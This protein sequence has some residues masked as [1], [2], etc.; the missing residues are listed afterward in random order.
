M[1]DD[2]ASRELA[3][4]I[5]SAIEREQLL[6]G[7]H[8]LLVACSGG[9]DSVVLF[10]L[11][12]RLAPAHG[13]ALVVAHLDHGWRADSTADAAFVEQ[14][15]DQHGLPVVAE[16]AEPMTRSGSLEQQFREARLEFLGRVARAH[17][18]DA[19]ALGHTLDDQ[20]ETILMRLARGAGGAGLAGMSARSRHGDLLLVRPL[21]ATGRQQLRDYAVAR[22]LEWRDDPSNADESFTRNRIRHSVMPELERAVPGASGSMARAAGLIDDDER[23]LQEVAARELG[24]LRLDDGTYG[25][26]TLDAT[27]LVGLPLALGR[28]VLREALHRLRGHLRGLE[29]GH[30]DAALEVAGGGPEAARDLPGVRVRREGALLLLERLQRSVSSAPR[31]GPCSS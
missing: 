3:E 20:A 27:G 9:C 5:D 25:G 28:R 10:D 13:I 2:P 19:V 31:G 24:R 21:L 7:V 17:G 23:W 11:L 15:A 18:C 22:E 14:L 1:P 29:R 30:V 16:R 12:V 6:D 26:M 4:L 8:R